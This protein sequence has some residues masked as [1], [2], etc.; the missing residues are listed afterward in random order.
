[1]SAEKTLSN[2]LLLPELKIVKTQRLGAA[3]NIYY[4]VKVR[5]QEFCPYCACG[6]NW[7]HQYRE[8]TVRDA[9]VRGAGIIL[10]IKKRR[11]KCKSCRKVFHEP[12]PG[13]LPRKRFTQRFRRSLLWACD[14][15]RDLKRVRRAYRCSHHMIYKALYETLELNRRSRLNYPWPKTIGIDEHAFGRSVKSRKTRF[16]TMLVDFNNKRPYELVEGHS[17]PLLWESLKHIPGRENVTHVA[18]DLSDP[19][20]KFVK[21]FF[22]NAEMVADKFHV[23]RLL[24]HHIMRRR[25]EITGDRASWQAR[26][27]LLMSN[28]KLKWYERKTLW[29]YLDKFPELKEVYAFKESLHSLYRI[30]GYNRASKALTK[31]TDRMAQ[32]KLKEIK[33]LR[34]TLIKWRQEILNYFKTGITNAR[35]EGFN[36]VAKLLKR[37]GFGFKSFDNYRLRVLNAAI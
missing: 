24:N 36:H 9:P 18:L 35:T 31:L 37:N 5:K 21:E 28:K 33:T 25:K 8:V 7:V 16:V 17:G 20:K 19:Y 6:E 4:C 34:R 11:L 2:F 10:K 15:F 30:K 27:L 12:I 23:L 14:N 29:E 1:M 22:P 26:Q 32:S 13:V 3:G